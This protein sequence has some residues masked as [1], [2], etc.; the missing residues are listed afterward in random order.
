MLSRAV[1]ADHACC[2]QYAAQVEAI[3]LA[4][5]VE[6][7]LLAMASPW[8]ADGGYWTA[9]LR[10]PCGL[11]AGKAAPTFAVP[12]EVTGRDHRSE[13]V[14]VLGVTVRRSWPRHAS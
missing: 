11:S 8:A 2:W 13:A 4:L 9:R 3:F 10:K 14:G 1:R 5:T 12:T 7:A 6:S